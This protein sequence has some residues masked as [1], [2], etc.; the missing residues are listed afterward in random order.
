MEQET[1]ERDHGEGRAAHSAANNDPH[2]LKLWRCKIPPKVRVFWWKVS[3]DFIPC[4]S[5]LH[6]KHIEP[7]GTC[8]L[9]GKEDETIFHALTQCTFAINFWEKLRSRTGIKLPRLCSRTWTRDLLENYFCK[10][11]DR[12]VILCGMWWLWLSRNDRR[13][14]KAPIHPGAAMEWALEACDQLS[15]SIPSNKETGMQQPVSWTPPEQGVLKLNTDGAFLQESCT[16]ATGAVL[17]GSDGCFRAASARWMNS[18][19]SAPLA[20]A[21]ALRDGVRLRPRL[22]SCC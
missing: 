22:V 7:I 18:V 10:E 12:G 16:G 13:H 1:Q 14:G 5:N 15:T 6:R 3:H 21:E 4:R 19:G 20:E 2:W 9:C 17:R 8:E 11:E